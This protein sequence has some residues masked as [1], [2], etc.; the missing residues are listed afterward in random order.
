M[1]HTSVK[2][3]P[4]AMAKSFK[5]TLLRGIALLGLIVILVLGAWGIILL[6]FNLPSFLGNVSEGI[7]GLFTTREEAPPPMDEEEPAEEEVPV[8]P[9]AT[10]SPAPSYVYTPAPVPAPQLYGAPDLRVQILSVMPYGNRYIMQ[11]MVE[12]TG[13]NVAWSGWN[14][15]AFLPLN[16]AYTYIAP[17]QQTLN[18]GDKIVYTLTFDA[19]RYGYGYDYRYDYDW[20]HDRR[21]DDCDED[22]D[23][24]SL[25]EWE[26]WYEDVFNRDIG[27]RDDWSRAD[28]EEWY[29]D[30]CDD[31]DL[32]DHHNYPPYPYPQPPLFG[33]RQISVTVDPQNR[34]YESNEYN[35]SAS[36]NL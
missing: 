12:N 7:S 20:R 13:T 30:F 4:P 34:V 2:S 10:A 26:E 11:F 16:P 19:P 33:N 32:R 22:Y 36:W 9:S 14:F 35:N 21:Y 6:A 24:W 29:D 31:R 25:D 18:P 23:E 8:A 27:N 28:W 5:D 15:N 1:R 3:N 17:P